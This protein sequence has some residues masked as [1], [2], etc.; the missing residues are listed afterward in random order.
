MVEKLK[1]VLSKLGEQHKEVWLFALL[2][3]DEFVDKWSIIIS[4][5][6]STEENRDI[7]FQ[8][9]IVLLN[10]ELS[11]EELYSIAR[12]VFLKKDD[13]L[14]Q[15]LMKRSSGTELKSE[16]INGNAV[17]EGYIIESNPNLVWQT[18]S[19]FSSEVKS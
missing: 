2:K 3:M 15:E 5:P 8:E 19:L 14:I 11:E 18:D 16:P 13:H 6:W 4:A 12:I 17:H 10:N 9:I 1:K 7:E